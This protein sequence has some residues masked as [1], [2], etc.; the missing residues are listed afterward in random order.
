MVFA[1]SGVTIVRRDE[2]TKDD[3]FTDLSNRIPISS[4]V[5]KIQAYP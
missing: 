5:G 1:V 2:T 3:R 4:A